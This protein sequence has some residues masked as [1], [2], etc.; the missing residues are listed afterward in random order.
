[1]TI[2]SITPAATK[3]IGNNDYVVPSSGGIPGWAIALMV[4]GGLL[5]FSIWAVF[6][7]RARH[8]NTNRPAG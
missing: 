7:R 3:R 5:L 2:S 8:N 1:V 6:L 4:I